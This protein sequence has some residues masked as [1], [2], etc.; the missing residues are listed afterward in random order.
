MKRIHIVGCSPRSGTTLMKELIINCFDVDLYDEGESSIFCLP[1][2]KANIYVTKYPGDIQRID[3]ILDR[4][5]DLY[6]ICMLRDPRDIIVSV[7]WQDQNKFWCGLKYWKKWTP[8]IDKLIYHPRFI[9]VYYE[10]LVNQPNTVQKEINN[11]LSFLNQKIPFTEF[12]RYLQPTKDIQALSGIRAINNA[13]IS[14]WKKH[15]PRIKGQIK[16]HGSIS[17]DLI[18]YGYEKDNDW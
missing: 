10:K 7:H 3:Y 18:K 16:L 13:S 5:K 9:L 1:K 11:K 15:I 17:D 6:V 8:Y 4:M 2:Y 12:H 14:N